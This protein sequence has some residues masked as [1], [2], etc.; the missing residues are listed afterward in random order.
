MS[1]SPLPVND[2]FTDKYNVKQQSR[3]CNPELFHGDIAKPLTLSKVINTKS[4]IKIIRPIKQS[5]FNN[6]SA[7]ENNSLPGY[8]RLS[9][10]TEG[11]AY[12]LQE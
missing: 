6:D 9:R 5:S 3:Y 4:S 2:E 1:L 10:F 7:Y 11:G 8:P 12:Q